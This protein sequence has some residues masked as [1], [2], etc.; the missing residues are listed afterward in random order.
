[1]KTSFSWCHGFT[2]PFDAFAGG[3]DFDGGELTNERA[4]TR[5]QRIGH[6]V[7]RY[8]PVLRAAWDEAQSLGKGVESGVAGLHLY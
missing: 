6:D 5:I 8:A 7:V 1:M 3:K 2:L 4:R